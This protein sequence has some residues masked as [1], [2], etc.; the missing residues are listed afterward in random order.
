MKVIAFTQH[1]CQPCKQLKPHL[2]AACEI[3]GIEVQEVD[4]VHNLDLVKKYDVKST[5]TVV[6]I[7]KQTYVEL[8][9][10]NSFK[11]VEEINDHLLKMSS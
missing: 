4:V 3:V 8:K 7:S 2:L 6:L 11:L 9:E 1:A 10:R 5:P